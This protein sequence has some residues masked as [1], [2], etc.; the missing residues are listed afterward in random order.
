MCRFVRTLPMSVNTFHMMGV[1][2]VKICIVS[3]DVV[4]MHRE[5][6]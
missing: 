6:S 4:Y 2:E 3:S 5:F 1:N